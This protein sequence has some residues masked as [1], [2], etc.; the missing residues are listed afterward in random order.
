MA[1]MNSEAARIGDLARSGERMV[2]RL[3]RQAFLP[4]SRKSLEVRFGIAEVASLLGCSTNRIRTAEEDKRPPPPPASEIGRRIGY[5][6]SDLLNM[7]EVLDAS[8]VRGPSDDPVIIAVQ[9]FKGGV[10][11]STVTTHLAHYLAL[12]GYRVLVVD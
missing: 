4:D 11:K 12:A 7:R 10:G 5:T 6:I 2:E 1:Q 8:P 3:R 9:N